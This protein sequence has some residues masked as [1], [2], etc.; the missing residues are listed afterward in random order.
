MSLAPPRSA[1][2]GFPRPRPTARLRLFCL[3]FAGGGAST[4][5]EWSTYL[6]DDVEVCPI[7]LP[8]RES[9]FR[10]PAIGRIDLVV[11]ELL[12][13]LPGYMDRPFALFG[14]SMGA[15]IGFELARRLRYLALEPVHFF[16]SGCRGPHLVNRTPP[17]Y[18]LPDAEFIAA[19]RNLNGV[20]S[21]VLGD[22][23]LMEL[24]LPT[25]RG[26]FRLAETYV[27]R[28]QPPLRCPV[29]AVGGLEDVEV[30]REDLEA[31]S[32]HT[33]GQFQVHVLPG[34]HFFLS[35]SRTALLRLI[36]LGLKI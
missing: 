30:T 27:C 35:S 3:P 7:L 14:H 21:E 4:F 22:D 24:M 32:S 34:N 13:A 2:V 20:P 25:I 9:R 6:P 29:T 11:D 10:E 16:A 15:M 36:R 28:P 17:R 33:T 26:D 1:W 12:K 23:E 5:R 18:G 8:G 31:W 19:L